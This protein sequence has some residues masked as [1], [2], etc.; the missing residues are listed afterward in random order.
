MPIFLVDDALAKLPPLSWRGI[1]VPIASLATDGGHDV[2]EHK[3]PDRAGARLESTGELP[4]SVHVRVLLRNGIQL[5]QSPQASTALFPSVADAFIAALRDGTTGD[6]VHPRFGTMRCKVIT[7]HESI[8][9]AVRDGAAYDVVWKETNDDDSALGLSSSALA[10][11]AVEA[12]QLDSNL[13][14]LKAKSAALAAAILGANPPPSFA[15]LVRSIQAAADMVTFLSHRGAGSIDS[16]VYQV[17]NM[18]AALDRAADAS[19]NAARQS[20]ERLTAAMYLMKSSQQTA[21]RVGVF[22]VPPGK[23]LTMGAIAS[24]TQTSPSDLFRLNPSLAG[25]ATARAGT[26]VRYYLQ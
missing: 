24:Q 25:T 26:L 6:L 2:A 4:R 16:V 15:D 13:A 9:A 17:G 14:A 20:C 22:T 8:E 12:A 18:S 5:D 11:A 3:K 19:T 7:W 21:K 23:S 10:S 1:K